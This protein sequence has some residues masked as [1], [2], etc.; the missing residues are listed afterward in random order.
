MDWMTFFGVFFI[1][2]AV[3]LSVFAALYWISLRRDSGRVLFS[4]TLGL[5]KGCA[6]DWSI[7]KGAFSWEPRYFTRSNPNLALGVPD[8]V[9]G[10]SVSPVGRH[11]G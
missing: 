6:S 1:M 3:P 9:F 11:G 5:M 2:M 7:K 4:A 10:V 8:S